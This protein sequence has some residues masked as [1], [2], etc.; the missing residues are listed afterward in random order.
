ML[1]FASICILTV[2]ITSSHQQQQL[3]PKLIDAI[4]FKAQNIGSKLKLHCQAQEGSRPLRFTWQKN[5]RKIEED[6]GR[7]RID[8]SE[9][10]ES[11]LV[12]EHLQASDG[13]NYTCSLSNSFGSVHQTT[14]VIVKGFK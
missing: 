2:F 1:F 11:L 3:P 7:A 8:S 13:A 10:E 14:V 6:S 12:I 5:D 4:A 9:E